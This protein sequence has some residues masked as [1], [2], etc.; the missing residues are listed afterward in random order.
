[1]SHFVFIWSGKFLF[2]SGVSQG[3][4][5]TDVRGNHVKLTCFIFCVLFFMF[6]SQRR[7]KITLGPRRLIMKELGYLENGTTLMSNI[8]FLKSCGTL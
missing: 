1:M 4:L 5:K 6:N 7:E 3:I 8:L 2:L